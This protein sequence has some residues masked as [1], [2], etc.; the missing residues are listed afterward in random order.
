MLTRYDHDL[1]VEAG[2]ASEKGRRPDNQDYVGVCFGPCGAGALPGVVAAVAD[3]VGGHKGGRAAAE[4]AVRSFMDGYYAQPETIGVIRA[5]ARS[6][7]AANAWIAAQGRVDPALQ[8][9]ATTFSAVILSRRAA[10]VVHVGDTRVYRLNAGGLELLTQDHIV[11]GGDFATLRRA[12]GFEEALLLDQ[13]SISLALHDRFLIC[14]DGVHGSLRNRALRGMLGERRSPQETAET[15][16]E[17]ALRAGSSDNATALVLDVVDL[18]PADERALSRA[19]EALPIREWPAVGETLDGFRLESILFEGRYSLLMRATDLQT[20]RSLALKFPHPR[21]AED[22]TYRLAFVNEAWVAARV[23]SPFIGEI[24]ELPPGRQTRLYSAM[25]FYEGETLEQRLRRKPSVGLAEGQLIA[26]RLS[27]AVATLHRSGVIHRDVKPDNVMLL[28]EG[29]LKLVDLGVCRAPR[30]DDFSSQDIPG[31]PSYMAPELFQGAVGDES[32][33]LYATGVTI[34]RMFT[35]AYPYGE[36]EPFC[37]PRF[38]RPQALCAK[39]PDLPAW[40]D[41][42][43]RKAIA[44]DPRDRFGDVLEFGFEIENG[45]ARSGPAPLRKQSLYERNPLAFWQGLCLLLACLLI[46]S[47]ALR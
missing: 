24:V 40:L 23:R 25:P 26:T 3:G 37:K 14:S 19:I 16:V 28:R 46:V 13:A 11:G 8:G 5:A 41:L 20:G 2:F 21:V 10:F 38:G 18:P 36:V 32:S 47:L 31:T 15:I 30:L 44:V 43:V 27:R 9:M 7:E 17:A 45:A 35:G 4:T 22:E 1:R 39:R 42:A 33:D 6:L 12:M 34:Y 29:G